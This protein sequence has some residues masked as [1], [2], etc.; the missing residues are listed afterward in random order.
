MPADLWLLSPE[1]QEGQE[2]DWALSPI[3]TQKPAPA[4]EIISARLPLPKRWRARRCEKVDGSDGSGA[5]CGESGLNSTRSLAAEPDPRSVGWPTTGAS[6]TSSSTRCW[7]WV[8]KLDI[9]IATGEQACVYFEYTPQSENILTT[10]PRRAP[11]GWTAA[12]A[13]SA[14]AASSSCYA[15]HA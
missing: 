12:A 13:A 9:E 11:S 14:A 7:W 3:K 2:S 6:R 10:S 4:N 1:G 8:A 15:G 5:F